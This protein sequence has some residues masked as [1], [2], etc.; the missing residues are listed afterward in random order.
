MIAINEM[1][2]LSQN[3]GSANILIGETVFVGSKIL[4]IVRY[5]MTYY[6][7]THAF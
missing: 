2:K 5:F 3:R 6:F 4:L 7:T 1:T